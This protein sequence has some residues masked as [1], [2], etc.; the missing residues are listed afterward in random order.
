MPLSTRTLLAILVALA[1]LLPALAAAPP[2]AR[3]AFRVDIQPRSLS[4][5]SQ[6]VGTTSPPQTVTVTNTGTEPIELPHCFLGDCYIDGSD[7]GDF[8]TPMDCAAKSPLQPGQ[9]CTERVT[10]TPTSLG[11]LNAVYHVPNPA[12]PVVQLCGVGVTSDLSGHSGLDLCALQPGDIL[13]ERSRGYP[14]AFKCALLLGGTYFSHAGLYLGDGLV[15]EAVGKRE[16]PA[17]EVTISPVL[18]TSFWTGQDQIDWAVIRPTAGAAAKQAAVAY[19][20]G[21]ADQSDPPVPYNFDFLNKGREDALYCSQLPW[22]AYQR[23]GL[24]LETE[25]GVLSRFLPGAERVVTPDD[26]YYSVG[27]G[28]ATL[29]QQKQ[30]PGAGSQLQRWLF[31]LFSPAELLVVDAQGRRTGFDPRTGAYRSEIPGTSY[32]GGASEP[33][34]LTV[35]AFDATWT[36]Y[37]HGTGAGSYTLVAEQ[38]EAPAGAEQVVT[39]PAVPGGVDAFAVSSTGLGAPLPAPSSP[40]G[41]RFGDV[42]GSDPACLAIEALAAR[43]IINGCDPQGTPPRFCPQD[44]TLRHQMAAL[45]VRA[46]PGW[47]GESHPYGF[48]DPTDDA[49][50][51]AR[52][53]TLRHHGV[54]GGYR[55]ETCAGLGLAAPCYG[56]LDPVL[57]AQAISFVT[58][59]MVAKGYWAQQ[60]TDP[61]L[62]GGALLGTGHEGDATTYWYYT[63]AKGGVPDHPEGG[64][65]PSGQ[66]A[67]RG[68]FARLLWTALQGTPAAP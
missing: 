12:Q 32:I 27:A 60:P 58:R 62:Y 49:E 16:D 66:A 6:P 61:N 10:F 44:T 53:G 13:L 57:K 18:G 17:D 15:A 46:M 8:D 39:R 43:G 23:Q 20:R 59:A 2:P 41:R 33:K 35:L 11:V 9:S 38:L 25:R 34:T 30:H 54:V 48:S 22:K 50:L 24:D 28:K 40:C 26:L 56:P 55:A 4:F 7:P 65:F 47:A 5:G 29:V 19:A 67:P 37:V 68:W 14:L 64:G 31:Q 36:L 51:M 1:L 3:A 21:K 42:P 45:I 52:V 63:R